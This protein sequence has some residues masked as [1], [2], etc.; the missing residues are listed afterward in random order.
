[1]N[2]EQNPTKP[3]LIGECITNHNDVIRLLGV[4]KPKDDYV[5]VFSPYLDSEY[6]V[7]DLKQIIYN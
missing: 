1:M 6:L 2:Q 7:L 3:T 4:L 5:M